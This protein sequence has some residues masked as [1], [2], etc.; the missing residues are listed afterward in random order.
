MLHNELIID[1]HNRKITRIT[2]Y[3]AAVVM[4]E[5]QYEK[6]IS[7]NGMFKGGN[8]RT[9]GEMPIAEFFELQRL[10]NE[11]GEELS[12]KDLTNWLKQRPQYLTCDG[13]NTGHHNGGGRIRIEKTGRKIKSNG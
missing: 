1:P 13:I 10:A 11:R 8:G 12:G 5:A 4:T 3:D 6:D 2:T 9:L 7:R